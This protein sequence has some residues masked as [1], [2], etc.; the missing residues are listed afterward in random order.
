[1][2]A[3]SPIKNK[4]FSNETIMSK[5]S[6]TA[7]NIAH[8]SFI[9][10]KNN[11]ILMKNKLYLCLLASV[12]LASCTTNKLLYKPY[13]LSLPKGFQKL[14]KVE[15]DV[16]LKTFAGPFKNVTFYDFYLKDSIAIGIFENKNKNPEFDVINQVMNS[17]EVNIREATLLA[18]NDEK[19]DGYQIVKKSKFDIAFTNYHSL[20]NNSRRYYKGFHMQKEDEILTGLMVYSQ[21]DS[22][23]SNVILNRVIESIKIIP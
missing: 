18:G 22:V 3:S 12:F 20:L 5:H 7:M 19:Y 10:F 13:Q 9:T 4:L 6:Q 2:I 21:P 1:M 16:L 15:A 8:D 17:H 23:A 14:S 11:Y